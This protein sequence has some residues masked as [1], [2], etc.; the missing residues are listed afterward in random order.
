MKT[1]FITGSF[2]L[3]GSKVSAYFHNHR[4]AVPGVD[5]NRRSVFFGHRFDN[6]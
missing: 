1:V 3:I 5:I 2:G 6:R 4:F